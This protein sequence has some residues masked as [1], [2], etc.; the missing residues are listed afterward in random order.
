MHLTEPDARYQ[1]RR[2]IFIGI[3]IGYRAGTCHV[4][5]YQEQFDTSSVSVLCQPHRLHWQLRKS[6]DGSLHVP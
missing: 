4:F 6:L 2:Q 5:L 1:S 3:M